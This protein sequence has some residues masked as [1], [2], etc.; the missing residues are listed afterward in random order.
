MILPLMTL[1]WTLVIPPGGQRP[2]VT[3]GTDTISPS[4]IIFRMQSDRCRRDTL[5]SETRALL[6]VVS[7]ELEYQTL[8][9]AFGEVPPDSNVE[10]V[11]GM[12]PQVTH[13]SE[14]LACILHFN[15]PVNFREDYVRP[16]LVNPRLHA[17][18]SADTIIHRAARD[19][20]M[21]IFESLRTHPERFL[22]CHLDTI[23]IKRDAETENWPLVRTVLSKLGPRKLW[24]QIVASDYDFSIVMLDYVTDS[25]YH[26]L[27]TRVMKQSFDSWFRDFVANHI[28]IRILN[29]VILATLRHDY[30]TLWWLDK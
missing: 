16:T 5:A 24:P 14:A 23:V 4:R 21:R 20:I 25:S 8:R 22:T 28:P 6:E 3:I 10:R 18:F 17:L 2:V 9:S 29:K 19:S 15:D 13:D 27:A 7:D 1:L 11:A 26:V 12:L 30:P